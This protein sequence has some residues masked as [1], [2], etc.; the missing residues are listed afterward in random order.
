[1][2]KAL[3]FAVYR[4]NTKNKRIVLVARCRT[5]ALAKVVVNFT[6]EK[7]PRNSVYITGESPTVIV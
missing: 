1:M 7:F 5:R 3:P 6:R 4:R 2:T